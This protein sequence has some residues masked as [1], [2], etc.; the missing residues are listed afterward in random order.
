[1][2][3]RI[4]REVM[5]L[6][7]MADNARRIGIPWT[8]TPG[9]VFEKDVLGWAIERKL[10][11]A[12]TIDG[13]ASVYRITEAGTRAIVSYEVPD[14]PDE[15]P[16]RPKKLH[17]S[18]EWFLTKLAD[19]QTV[20]D[21]WISSQQIPLET[22][23][24]HMRKVAQERNW[25]EG[26]GNNQ[27]RE[28]KIT[29]KGMSLLNVPAP[30]IAPLPN[31]VARI[32][33]LSVEEKRQLLDDAKARVRQRQAAAATNGELLH[34]H[35]ATADEPHNAPN[36]CNSNCE[37]CVYHEAITILEKNVPGVRGLV[38]GLL[39]IRGQK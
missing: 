12:N 15:M 32:S 14:A 6:L 26:R 4:T 25:V 27:K 31:E 39:T 30:A 17:S 16:L 33:R 8:D 20:N 37:H 29:A 10:V 36:G 9:T 19:Y 38:D 24:Y 3:T 5:D 34:L 2:G 28:F 7:I 18:M 22:V 13:E 21:G 23:P 35:A 1:M 11:E